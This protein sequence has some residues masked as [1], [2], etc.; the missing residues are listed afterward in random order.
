MAQK[1]KIPLYL[2]NKNAKENESA[3]EYTARIRKQNLMDNNGW[4]EEEYKD[5]LRQKDAEYRLEHNSRNESPQN[6]T[7][8]PLIA[9]KKGSNVAQLTKR[10][11]K[12][13]TKAESKILKQQAKI[14]NN[15]R[16]I[17]PYGQHQNATWRKSTNDQTVTYPRFAPEQQQLLSQLMPLLQQGL[18]NL[19]LPGGNSFDP[20]RQRSLN[21]F[22]EKIVPT[23][24]ERFQSL[25]GRDAEGG[26]LSSGALHQQ[27]IAGGSQLER[28]LADL[29]AQHS[30]LT[31]RNLTNL[32]GTSLSPQFD[33][34]VIPGQNSF[35]RNVA[36]GLGNAGLN[37]A[38]LG[39]ARAG[40]GNSGITTRNSN[41][42]TYQSPTAGAQQNNFGQNNGYQAGFGINS[43]AQGNGSMNYNG[44]INDIIN[45]YK[46]N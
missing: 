40:Q 30:D 20:I 9:S 7:S 11:M 31:S 26:A 43:P 38:S 1:Q 8:E 33:Y 36:T 14:S 28:Q 22:N 21:D 44:I 32:L 41:P 45:G 18:G 46:N 35:N 12:Q 5:Y 29:E 6:I 19:P 2:K 42:S 17:V 27:L 16:G 37:I 10:Q 25:G 15:Q 23:I 39:L 4:N 24:A 3:A 13:N 34:G